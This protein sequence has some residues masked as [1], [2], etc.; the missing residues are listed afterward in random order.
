MMR[1]AA[2]IVLFGATLVAFAS[3]QVPFRGA[4]ELVPIYATVTDNEG[5]LVPDLTKD[6]FEIRDDGTPQ[7][8]AVFSNE[9]QPITIIIML[10][11]SGSMMS[12]SDIVQ[13]GAETLIGQLLPADRARVGDFSQRILIRPVNFISDRAELVNLLRTALQ[14]DANG[15]SPI[16][17]AIGRTVAALN[18]ESG[19]RVALVFTDGH[20]EPGPGQQRTDFGEVMRRALADE[21]MVYSI[22]VPATMPRVYGY[23]NGRP[24][25]S[26]TQSEPPD[27][28][29]KELA[30][31]TGGGYLPFDWAQNLNETFARVADELHHQYVLGFKPQKLDGKT[32]A[33][34]LRVTRKNLKVRARR[35][36][37][38]S[39]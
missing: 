28:H 25:G 18:T 17:T 9:I 29:L 1:V 32:H 24:I 23:V 20:D 8:I 4:T 13:H 16:W 36:Y 7:P 14:R 10:D 3:P 15:P 38:A 19:R 39:R 27:K 34:D 21:V 11:R 12:H 37:I 31:A 33:I 26:G 6:D 22:G 35:S 5:R 2:L 30:E